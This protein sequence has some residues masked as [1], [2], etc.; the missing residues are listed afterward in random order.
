MRRTLVSLLAVSI[1][2]VS[3]VLFAQSAPQ[4]QQYYFINHSLYNV[5]K[6]ADNQGPQTLKGQVLQPTPDAAS[7]QGYPGVELKLVKG[8]DVVAKAITDAEGNF[9]IPNVDPNGNYKLYGQDPANPVRVGNCDV[10]FFDHSLPLDHSLS[11]NVTIGNAS[12]IRMV[13][14]DNSF[15]YLAETR[16]GVPPLKNNAIVAR[17][18]NVGTT[19]VAGSGG[20]AVAGG[21]FGGGNFGSL[22][23]LGAIG[24]M[25]A[26]SAIAI[27]DDDDN[28]T[29]STPISVG[30]YSAGKP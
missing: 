29:P 24:G 20:G 10:V 8:T 19:P 7:F 13:L 27:S 11:N 14:S 15:K 21:G 5:V 23:M 6:F 3:P 12:D 1:F 2:A 25:I 18:P 30:T 28:N 16:P 9:E 26:T 22:A 4:Q 17:P